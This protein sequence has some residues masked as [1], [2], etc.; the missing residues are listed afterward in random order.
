MEWNRGA[1]DEER[2]TKAEGVEL[3]DIGH[4]GLGEGG[5]SPEDLQGWEEIS[6]QFRP[7]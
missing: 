3:L 2:L 4:A 1:G 6:G 5:D 7:G